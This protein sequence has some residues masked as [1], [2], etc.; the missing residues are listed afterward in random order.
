MD[1]PAV[2]DTVPTR[3][4]FAHVRAWRL[5]KQQQWQDLLAP[6]LSRRLGVPEDDP[7]DPRP[8]ALAAAAL[9]CLDAADLAWTASDGKA[10]MPEL[11]KQA[12]A[13][14]RSDQ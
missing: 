14:V 1:R 5:E 12:M 10:D 9:G 4:A 13:A 6:E 11:I 8:R 7:C 3:Y 2:L